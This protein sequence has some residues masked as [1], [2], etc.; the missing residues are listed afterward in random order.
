MKSLW[1]AQTTGPVGSHGDCLSA[2]TTLCYHVGS[3]CCKVVYFIHDLECLLPYILPPMEYLTVTPTITHYYFNMYTL[4]QFSYLSKE[5]VSLSSSWV[6]PSSS[7][8]THYMHIRGLYEHSSLPMRF[9]GLPRCCS[10]KVST[11][12][13]RRRR[14]RGL[15]PWVRKIPLRRAWQPPPVFLTRESHGQRNL[16]GYSPW[17]HKE[18]DTT[19]WLS[20]HGGFWTTGGKSWKG[21]SLQTGSQD[22]R[23]SNPASGYFPL[24]LIDIISL[25]Y[26]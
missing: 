20:T 11:F 18:L 6:N 24:F 25:R 8:Q 4:D 14:G 13:C 2:P 7:H 19:M 15:D 17:S 10:G 23:K 5:S 16:E 9:R 1:W 21:K 3:L 26:H 22:Q 12:Q